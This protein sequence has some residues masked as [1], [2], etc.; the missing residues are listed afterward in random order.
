MEVDVEE[1][2]DE[3]EIVSWCESLVQGRTK[4]AMLII[5]SLYVV[6]LYAK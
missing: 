2:D 6:W 1:K 4:L 5:A 3:T